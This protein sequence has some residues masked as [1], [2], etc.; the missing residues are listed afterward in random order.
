[1]S[2][3]IY[4]AQAGFI[5]GRKIADNVILAHELV[6]SYTRAQISPKCMI[7]ID[8]QKAYDSVEWI[9]PQQVMEELGFPD[10]FIKWIIECIKTINYTILVNGETTEPFN[11][12]KG[13]RQRDLISPFLFAIFLQ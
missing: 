3:I 8:L 6:K 4:E 10:R 1:M 7:K 5:H 9:V 11:A 12:A 2:F 13:L